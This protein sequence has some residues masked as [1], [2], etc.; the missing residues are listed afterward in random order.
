MFAINDARE[1]M[2]LRVTIHKYDYILATLVSLLS[3]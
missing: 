3:N 2:K 1:L